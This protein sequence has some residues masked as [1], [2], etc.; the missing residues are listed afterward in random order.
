MRENEQLLEAFDL[1]AL[2]NLHM[3]SLKEELPDCFYTFVQDR[4]TEKVYYTE[5][6]NDGSQPFTYSMDKLACFN[7]VY[8]FPFMLD[9]LIENSNCEIIVCSQSLYQVL[10]RDSNTLDRRRNKENTKAIIQRPGG[11]VGVYVCVTR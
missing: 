4:E 3:E 2:S 10:S 11:E 6:Y 9:F 8:N 7:D 5:T 1:I